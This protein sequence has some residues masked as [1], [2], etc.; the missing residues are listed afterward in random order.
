MF[1]QGRDD[2]AA[3]GGYTHVFVDSK[4]R[5]SVRMSEV[6]ENGLRKLTVDSSVKGK[7]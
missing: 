7:L 2:P 1:E 6:L 5:K 3:V 4:T